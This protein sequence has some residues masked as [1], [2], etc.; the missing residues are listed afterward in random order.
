MAERLLIGVTGPDSGGAIAWLMTALAIRRCGAKP[1]RITPNRRCDESQLHAVVIG[2]G[3]DVDPFHYGEDSHGLESLLQEDDGEAGSSLLDWLVGLVLTLFRAVFARHSSQGY[4]P[5]RDELEKHHIQYALYYNKPI[6][7]ICRGAQLMNVTLGGSL[8]QNIEHFYTEETSNIRSILPRK[9]V[10][11]VPSSRLRQ[12][13]DK[14]QC[15]VNALHDQS[16]KALGDEVEVSAVEPTGVI[17][18]IERPSH[19]F[20]IGVQWH[21]EYIPQSRTQQSL[22]RSLVTSARQRSTTDTP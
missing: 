10:E 16:I 22:F 4:D 21:P 18:A 17:Q 19:P 6:L 11:L 7:G 13:L 15:R 14:A 12:I 20:F 8:H 5:D 1:V 3:T 2:G 9:S